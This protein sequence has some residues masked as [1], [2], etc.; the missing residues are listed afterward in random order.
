MNRPPCPFAAPPGDTSGVRAVPAA[1]A[2]ACAIV[3]AGSA[4][5]AVREAAADQLTPEDLARK[6]E[7]GYFTGLPLV[8]YSTDIGLGGGAR[9]Y[10]YWNGT[11][12]DP[13]FAQTPYL[14]RVFLQAFASTRGLQFHWLDYDAPR[15]MGSPYRVRSQ[16]IFGRNINSNYFGLGDAALLPL[17]FPGQ[18]RTF[19]SYADYTEA[20]R[21]IVDG[22]AYTK[23]DQYEL[24]RPVFVASVERLLLD[25]KVR[26][27]AGYGFTYAVIRDYTGK[28]VDAVDGG[29]GD[30]EAPSAPTRLRADCDAGRL[31]GCDGGR[32]G[33]LR[34]G[35]SYDTRDFEPD[36]N[37]GVFAD[38]A[39]D[40]ATV[41]LGSEYDYLRLLGAVRGYWS[42]APKVT[43]LVLAGRGLLQFQTAGT[44]F[45]S[46]DSLPFTEDFRNGLGGHRTLRGFRQNRFV[47][48][49]MAAV[50]GEVRWTFARFTLARQ[51]LALIAVP[52]LDVGRSFDHAGKLT[53]SDWRPS[54]GGALR[55]SW[56]LATIV[57]ADYGRSDEDTGLYINFGHIF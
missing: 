1:V 16:L 40:A 26:L 39:L 9:G 33:F 25:D 22:V 41:A 48:R 52:F 53:F 56:N 29:G 43:D 6:N 24:I 49:T 3:S 31:I 15:L 35:I 14:H 42:P 20:Q 46:L 57:T 12:G 2:L 30:T 37:S 10:Y 51:K 5:R 36:P 50:T 18:D 32:E 21:R 23:Y 45:F 17:R 44:P 27:L 38:L 34:L 47:G 7:G 54:Y 4:I 19:D 55:I 8:S 28:Q 13:R 11:R